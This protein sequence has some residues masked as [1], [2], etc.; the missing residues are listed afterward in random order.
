VV[1]DAWEDDFVEN[2]HHRVSG[3]VQEL[4]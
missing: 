2:A 1:L 3:Q 4:K